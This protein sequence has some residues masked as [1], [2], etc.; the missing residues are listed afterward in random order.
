MW[1]G[2]GLNQVE[3]LVNN[4]L[5]KIVAFSLYFSRICKPLFLH[6][7]LWLNLVHR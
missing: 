4:V 5:Q 7:Q 6:P 2:G 3:G 1:G